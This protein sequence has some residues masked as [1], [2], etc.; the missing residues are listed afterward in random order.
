MKTHLNGVLIPGFATQA[1]RT[2][3][4]NREVA[5]SQIHPSTT[6]PYKSVLLRIR[7]MPVSE[8]LRS[9]QILIN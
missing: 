7:G 5:I 9:T 2:Q 4:L 1:Q 3:E 6:M 8:P